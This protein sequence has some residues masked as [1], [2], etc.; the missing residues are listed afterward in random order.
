MDPHCAGPAPITPGCTRPTSKVNFWA[1]ISI[2]RKQGCHQPLTRLSPQKGPKLLRCGKPRWVLLEARPEP[3]ALTEST[4][5]H[6]GAREGAQT[7]CWPGKGFTRSRG[8]RSGL[9]EP[10]W[11]EEEHKSQDWT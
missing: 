7:S 8:Q 6:S 1:D 4:G 10:L 9:R 3:W 2:Q 11:S 5:A